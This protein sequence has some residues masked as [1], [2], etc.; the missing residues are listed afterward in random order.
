MSRPDA[1]LVVSS[2]WLYTLYVYDAVR[3]LTGVEGVDRLV[4]VWSSAVLDWIGNAHIRPFTTV[5]CLLLAHTT[6][7]LHLTAT[8]GAGP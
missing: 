7:G 4:G 3:T 1:L 6:M 5:Y 8:A 2:S